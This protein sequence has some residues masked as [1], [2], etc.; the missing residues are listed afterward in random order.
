L[1]MS[2]HFGNRMNFLEEL[3]ER[4]S[5]TKEAL[6]SVWWDPEVTADS[7][8]IQD[9]ELPVDRMLEFVPRLSRSPV[10]RCFRSFSPCDQNLNQVHS[11]FKSFFHI[12]IVIII[13][14]IKSWTYASMTFDSLDS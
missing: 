1:S 10:L 3:N 13:I 8:L 2:S 4:T 12:N 6:E 11:S 9:A 14:I 5:T 7:L